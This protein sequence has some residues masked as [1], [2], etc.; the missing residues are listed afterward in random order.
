MK[1]FTAIRQFL[2]R[3]FGKKRPT[4]SAYAGRVCPYCGGTGLRN[5]T[6]M[7]PLQLHCDVCGGK[8]RI[9]F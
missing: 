3:R 5:D 1:M 7:Y 4:D 9:P 6:V 8:G 2:K